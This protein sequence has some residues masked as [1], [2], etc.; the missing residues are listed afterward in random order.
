MPKVRHLFVLVGLVG[1]MGCRAKAPSPCPKGMSEVPRRSEPGRSVWCQT[2]DQKRAQWIEWHPKSTQPRQSCGY[3]DGR[4]EGA[5]T[6]WFP[7]GKLWV[8]GQFTDG[9]KAG[10]WKQWDNAGTAV[11]E[12]DYRGGRLIAGAPVAGMAMC[13]RAAKP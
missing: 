13:E 10:K 11:A 12:G 1:V 3:Y 7:S 8:Q 4:P 2:A 6:A 5:F 9:Q